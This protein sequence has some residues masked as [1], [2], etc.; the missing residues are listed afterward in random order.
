[1]ERELLIKHINKLLV[2][3][4]GSLKI[5]SSGNLQDSAVLSEYFFRDL[6]NCAYGWQL[7]DANDTVANTPGY[8]LVDDERRIFVQV[9]KDASREKIKKSLDKIDLPKYA[10]YSIKFMFLVVQAPKYRPMKD[11]D[12]PKGLAF[13]INS[14]IIDISRLVKQ[15]QSLQ[16]DE[17]KH[18]ADIVDSELGFA[19][20]NPQKVP[21]ALSAVVKA[22]LTKG[23][24][25]EQPWKNPV[26]FEIVAKIRANGLDE[27][28]DHI[29]KV[30]AYTPYLETIYQAYDESGTNGRFAMLNMLNGE[31]VKTHLGSQDPYKTFFALQDTL[32]R[33][34]SGDVD[35]ARIDDAT[36][37][38]CIDIVLVDAFMRCRIYKGP[39]ILKPPAKESEAD[40]DSR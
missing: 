28:E 27:L 15:L 34:I 18:A 25:E 32:E 40:H 30:A 4:C 14:D 12:V 13:D 17:L 9:S 8:D 6:L 19:S 36:R 31:Y 38:L 33:Q 26:L 1:M 39:D 3:H 22:L 29:Q 35:I 24:L 37:L 7:E 5:D 23:R 11:N 20:V 16:I 21:S 10:D 2:M